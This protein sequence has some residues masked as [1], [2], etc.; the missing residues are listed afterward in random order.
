MYYICRFIFFFE[1]YVLRRYL[2]FG[3]L[4]E[5]THLDVLEIKKKQQIKINVWRGKIFFYFPHSLH[6]KGHHI[7][8]WQRNTHNTGV[9]CQQSTLCLLSSQSEEAEMST[10][11]KPVWGW[12]KNHQVK[13][14]IM[15]ISKPHQLNLF[16]RKISN[17]LPIF[18]PIKN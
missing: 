13:N 2:W 12:S 9:A 18:S 3:I 1:I 8:Y 16:L 4:R 17:Y 7:M 11:A 10:W 15:Q 6:W 14:W 5:R